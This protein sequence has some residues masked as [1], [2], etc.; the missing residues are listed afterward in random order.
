MI[1]SIIEA[2]RQAYP[3]KNIADLLYLDTHCRRGIFEY[4]EKRAAVA[5]API[6]NYLFTLEH[7][8]NSGS[9][10]FHGAE[11][12]YVFHN[13]DFLE[14]SYIPGVTEKLQDQ[15]AAAWVNFARTGNPS[16]GLAPEW[17][18]VYDGNGACM[19][20]DEESACLF[21][22]DRE[23]MKRLPPSGRIIVER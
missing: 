13:A 23:L 8:I 2:F 10:A 3:K 7:T 18:P 15:V 6:Y 14:A 16:G 5:A 11:L 9:I 20:Y 19:V 12:A 21:G 4:T 1:D 17:K 22:H